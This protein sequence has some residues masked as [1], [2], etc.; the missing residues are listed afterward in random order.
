MPDLK[1]LR[2]IAEKKLTESRKIVEDAQAEVA[3]AQAYL[4]K[5]EEEYDATTSQVQRQLEALDLV[6]AM[7]TEAERTPDRYP[8]REMSQEDAMRTALIKAGQ[9]MNST[10]L[11]EALKQGGYP[12]RSTNP[13]NAIVVAANTN[14]N[15]YF[16]TNKENGRTLIGLKEWSDE[17]AASLE[18]I[19]GPDEDRSDIGPGAYR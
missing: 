17:M 4:K 5:A 19:F 9:S 12:F 10:E 6:E 16:T 15:G 7:A 3:N 14:R 1:T 11:A 2:E 18:D 8:Y 13:A